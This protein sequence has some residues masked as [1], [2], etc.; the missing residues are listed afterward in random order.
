MCVTMSGSKKEENERQGNLK[1][2][3]NERMTEKVRKNS[4]CVRVE[5]CV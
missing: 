2:D 5:F 3:V 4:V 1:L